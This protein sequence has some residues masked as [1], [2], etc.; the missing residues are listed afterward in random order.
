VCDGVI[1]GGEHVRDLDLEV[2][3]V[4]RLFG[5]IMTRRMRTAGRQAHTKPEASSSSV[6]MVTGT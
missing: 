6:Q 5:M 2:R 3:D 4:R 1:V